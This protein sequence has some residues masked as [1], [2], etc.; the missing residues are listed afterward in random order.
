MEHIEKMANDKFASKGVYM[1]VK[2]IQ[3]D[4]WHNLA[5]DAVAHLDAVPAWTA[6]QSM[7][8]ALATLSPQE[9]V[10]PDFQSGVARLRAA[11]RC[12]AFPEMPLAEAQKMLFSEVLSFF[13][14]GIDL[15]DRLAVRAAFIAYGDSA[16]DFGT[17]K[18]AL[19]SNQEK[20]GGRGIGEWLALFDKAYDPMKRNNESII[21]FLTEGLA[22]SLS[23]NEREILKLILIAYENWLCTERLNIF[24]VAYLLKK[25]GKKY[26]VGM[27]AGI[28]SYPQNIATSSQGTPQRPSS[29]PV[30]LP[31][32]QALSKYESLGNQLVTSERIRVKSQTE[33][34]RPS[35]L[36]WLKYYRDELGIG[37]H[38]SVE[39]GEFLFRSDNGK[40]LSAEERERINLILKSVEENMPLTIDP[41]RSEIIFPHFETPVAAPQRA[42]PVEVAPAYQPP[43]Y[44][45][46]FSPEPKVVAAP[47]VPFAQSQMAFQDGNGR[48]AAPSRNTAALGAVSFSSSHVFPAE[49]ESTPLPLPTQSDVPQ[50]SSRMIMPE[51]VPPA[52]TFA[53]KFHQNPFRIRPV[54]LGEDEDD[55][56]K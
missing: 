39:R 29:E 14:N 44:Q 11:L 41:E 46:A 25:E 3:F 5:A 38:S 31:L 56:D 15:D 30:Q 50:A 28:L 16:F 40:R 10:S 54:S 43:V 32:L 1:A 33:P 12:V 45:P 8:Q 51:V 49:S 42:F 27:K 35:L 47:R 6:L 22:R 21:N 4:E 19:L 17:L 13:R 9:T 37:H 2:S 48:N 24:D 34:V 36:Y 55:T 7:E 26:S 23:G 52:K 20:I 18:G 53:P